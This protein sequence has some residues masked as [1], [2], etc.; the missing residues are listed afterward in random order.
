[1]E[2]ALRVPDGRSDRNE[3]RQASSPRVLPDLEADA[4][5]AVGSERLR[6]CFHPCHRKL[7]RVVQ[8]LREHVELS[9]PPPL[10]LHADVVNRAP[11]D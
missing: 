1:M 10:H 6:L 4:D 8:R 3:L 9:V 5:D 2:A 7:A 11:D